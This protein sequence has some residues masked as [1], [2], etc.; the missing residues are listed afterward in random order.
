MQELIRSTVSATQARLRFSEVIKRA[1]TEPKPIFV[2]KAGT[3]I[4][5]IL[6]LS[7]MRSYYGK[8]GSVVS[9]G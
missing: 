9:S 5:V 7:S 6:S 1:S 4:V 8:P 2:E 3:P